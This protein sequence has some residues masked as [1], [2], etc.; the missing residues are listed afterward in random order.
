[1][2]FGFRASG[3]GFGSGDAA[4]LGEGLESTKSHFSDRAAA[5]QNPQLLGR[6]VRAGVTSSMIPIILTV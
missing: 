1:M 5:P 3:L 2:F 4:C 6:N